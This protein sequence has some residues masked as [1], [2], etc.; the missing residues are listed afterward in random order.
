MQRIAEQ[1]E[2]YDTG[3]QTHVCESV[4]EKLHGPRF[5]GKP[6]LLYLR[7]LGVLSPRFSIAHGVWLTD[8]EIEAL[9]EAGAAVS[10]NPGSNLRLR[11]GIAPLDAL[12]KRSSTERL[13]RKPN[14]RR[15]IETPSLPEGLIEQTLRP[16]AESGADTTR[17]LPAAQRPGAARQ[18]HRPGGAGTT[19][20]LPT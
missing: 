18:G 20:G 17:G 4:Y 11:A 10:H 16:S 9:R 12:R 15:V 7:D 3:I 6:T 14:S 2:R 13:F 19:R 5:H 8:A 1:A